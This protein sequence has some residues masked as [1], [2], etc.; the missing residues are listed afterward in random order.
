ML[1]PMRNLRSPLKSVHTAFGRRNN[2]DSPHLPTISCSL[3]V[4]RMI[5]SDTAVLVLDLAGYCSW[6]NK[7]ELEV[8]DPCDHRLQ[9]GEGCLSPTGILSIRK[10]LPHLPHAKIW[11]VPACSR[12]SGGCPRDYPAKH[13][14]L[15]NLRTTVTKYQDKESH[16]LSLIGRS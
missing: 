15:A 6:H 9:N 13:S 4:S 10:H 7:L 1:H 8:G 5:R 12:A 16:L 3:M 14:N 11:G 2:N